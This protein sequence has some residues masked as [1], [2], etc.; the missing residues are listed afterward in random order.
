MSSEETCL[1]GFPNDDIFEVIVFAVANKSRRL[2]L[3][4]HNHHKFK[5]GNPAEGALI[6]INHMFE[7]SGYSKACMK[8]FQKN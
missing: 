3:S 8:N 4:A 7:K 6:F 1:Q 5:R 2:A